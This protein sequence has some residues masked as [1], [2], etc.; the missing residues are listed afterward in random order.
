[1]GVGLAG[2]RNLLA[3]QGMIRVLLRLFKP[4][5]APPKPSAAAAAADSKGKEKEKEAE[6]AEPELDWNSILTLFSQLIRCCKF[7]PYA[8][9]PFNPSLLSFS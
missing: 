4:V 1:V 7:T 8:P 2:A 6:D 3:K 9:S 5:P